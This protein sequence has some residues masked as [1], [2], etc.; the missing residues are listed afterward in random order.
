MYDSETWCTG[1]AQKW[2]EYCVTKTSTVW[3]SIVMAGI[4][5]WP[6]ALRNR[7]VAARFFRL[8]DGA[9]RSALLPSGGSVQM[10]RHGPRTAQVDR[11]R[12]RRCAI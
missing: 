1:S 8:S 4:P 6:L 3:L 5:V 10:R 2:V 11:G 12:D 9:F 7:S